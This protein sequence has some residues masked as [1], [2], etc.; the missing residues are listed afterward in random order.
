MVF[1]TGFQLSG[2][3][4]C[5]VLWWLAGTVAFVCGAGN[6]IAAVVENYTLI[7]FMLFVDK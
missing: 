2:V 1:N 5:G 6:L 4:K 7:Y 3:H